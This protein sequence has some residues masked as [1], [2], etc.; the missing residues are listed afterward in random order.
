MQNLID[1]LNTKHQKYGKWV[2]V[3]CPF[4][5][6]RIIETSDGNFYYDNGFIYS[7][8]EF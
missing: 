4:L 5:R 8:G 6:K 3:F 2:I 7:N 1:E